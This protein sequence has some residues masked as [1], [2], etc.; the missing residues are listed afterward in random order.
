MDKRIVKHQNQPKGHKIYMVKTQK[1]A[2]S[3]FIIPFSFINL[4]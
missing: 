3:L 1:I 4:L 2:L